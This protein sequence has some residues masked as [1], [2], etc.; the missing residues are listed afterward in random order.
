MFPYTSR[1]K[2]LAKFQLEG[3]YL[4]GLLGKVFSFPAFIL[5]MLLSWSSQKRTGHSDVQEERK[6]NRTQVQPYVITN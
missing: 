6:G 3:N 2:T 4:Q 5:S 1:P